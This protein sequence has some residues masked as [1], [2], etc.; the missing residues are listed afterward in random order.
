MAYV[1][2]LSILL[3]WAQAGAQAVPLR[4][5]TTRPFSLNPNS[6]ITLAA[7]PNGVG[8]NLVSHGV[9]A[10]S[11]P[12]AITSTLTNPMSTSVNLYGSFGSA[13]AALTGAASGVA[14]P[15]ACVFGEV[16]TG[17]VTSFTAFTQSNTLGSAGAGLTL[18]SQM[19]LTSGQTR[20]DSLYLKIDLSTLPRVPADSYMGVLY[21]QAQ[22]F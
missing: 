20:T 19:G 7:S 16:P 1:A 21:L 17:A 15:S 3:A 4:N 12:I 9:A 22:I 8:F 18:V 14:I 10:A 2:G 13:P 6:S 11:G 5:P